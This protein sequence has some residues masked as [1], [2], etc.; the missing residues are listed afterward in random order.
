MNSIFADASFYIALASPSDQLSPAAYAVLRRHAGP[1]LT[2]TAV[3]FEVGNFLS[4]RRSRGS[5][6]RLMKLLKEN[7]SVRVM[8]E[9]NDLWRRALSLYAARLDKDWSLTDCLSFVVM[10]L[11]G[12]NVAATSDHHFEQAGFEILLK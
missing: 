12:V 3:L 9:S 7:D 2:T 1:Y 8:G 10:D 6:V 5:F 11:C 4:H